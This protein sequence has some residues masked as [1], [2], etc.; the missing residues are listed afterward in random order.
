MPASYDFVQLDVF[1]QMPLAG[2]PLAIFTGESWVEP[3]LKSFSQAVDTNQL[4]GSASE[5][6]L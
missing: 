5:K 3:D 2:N 6:E 1:T 4:S